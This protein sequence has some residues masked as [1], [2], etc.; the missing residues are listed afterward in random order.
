MPYDFPFL[1][2][3]WEYPRTDR[4]PG[5]NPPKSPWSPLGGT[6]PTPGLHWTPGFSIDGYSFHFMGGN[7]KGA[8]G[9]PDV[10]APSNWA[11]WNPP[12]NRTDDWEGGGPLP[13]K[14]LPAAGVHWE[15]QFWWGKPL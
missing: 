15:W 13:R 1:P 11:P 8:V 10:T 12:T 14:G 9:S 5:G 4:F 3:M 7:I 6:E 2:L